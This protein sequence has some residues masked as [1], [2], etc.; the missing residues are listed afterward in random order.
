MPSDMNPTAAVVPEPGQS[1][2]EAFYDAQQQGSR[3]SAAVVVPLVLEAFPVRSV[4]DVGC[5]VGGWLAEFRRRGVEDVL[6]VDGDYVPRDALKIPVD[7]FEARDLRRYA[8]PERRFDLACSLEVAEHL[9]AEV[10]DGFVAALV[11]AAPVVLFS[12]AVPG[13]G[14]TSHVNEQW[15]SYWFARFAAHGY[16]CLDLVRPRVFEDDRVEWW[17]RQNALV[18]CEPQ[19]HPESAAAISTAYELDRVHPALL[20]ARSNDGR[21]R[22]GREAVASIVE[23]VGYLGTAFK[24]RIGAD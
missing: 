10:A 16:A 17:Y 11:R 8:G 6:G 21:P 20:A 4:I 3:H 2:S 5:G 14:G 12:A 19:R 9:P 7:R 23:N 15:Q 22:S 24:R 13:Q 18:F 1:Y